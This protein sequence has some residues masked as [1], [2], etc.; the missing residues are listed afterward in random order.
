DDLAFAANQSSIRPESTTDL[1]YEDTTLF[2]KYNSMI[3]SVFTKRFLTESMEEN[4]WRRNGDLY[5]NVPK[6]KTGLEILMMT[7]IDVR[8]NDPRLIWDPLQFMNITYIYAPTYKVWTPAISAEN[9]METDPVA[10]H[11]SFTNVIIS[12]NGDILRVFTLS[13]LFT[14]AIRAGRFPFDT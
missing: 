2:D 13:V 11:D 3:P 1:A 6:A 4:K 9:V 7:I 8:W 5:G 10:D 14:C 12:A